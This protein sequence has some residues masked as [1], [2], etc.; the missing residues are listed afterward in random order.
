MAFH[1]CMIMTLY[2]QNSDIVQNIFF[3]FPQ[4]KQEISGIIFG[5]TIPLG[6][7]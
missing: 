1:T 5:W 4:K 3:Y 6:K 7:D 2:G